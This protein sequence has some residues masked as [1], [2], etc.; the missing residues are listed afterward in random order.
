MGWKLN[1]V[2]DS[3]YFYLLHLFSEVDESGS[4]NERMSGEDFF[5]SIGENYE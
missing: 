2:E 5:K 3:D 1:D 4:D